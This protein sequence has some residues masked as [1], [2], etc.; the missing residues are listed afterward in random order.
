MDELISA[1]NVGL[2]LGVRKYDHRR[3]AK[4]STYI[5]W[6]IKQRIV[7]AIRNQSK[8]VRVPSH[9]FE[10]WACIQNARALLAKEFGREPNPDDIAEFLDWPVAKINRLHEVFART[11]SFD[12]LIDGRG[13]DGRK[14]IETV[15]DATAP[16]PYEETAEHA[17]ALMIREVLKTL[18]DR[19]REI[20][21][22][23]Y[24]LTHGTTHT[25][26]QVGAMYG[27]TRERIRQIEA[28][29]LRRLR[30]KLD[31]EKKMRNGEYGN[32]DADLAAA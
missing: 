1:G 25:L 12:E 20:L 6:W 27:V 14:F 7:L 23:R 30:F 19:D 29:V 9:L 16:D 24:G 3:G 26:E 15:P 5:S 10:Q 18:P 8:T 13:E 22:L 17:D 2:M 21:D 11:I 31:H 4:I 28:R 32:P